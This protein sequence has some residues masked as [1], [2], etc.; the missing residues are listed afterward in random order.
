[1]AEAVAVGN[2]GVN[3]EWMIVITTDHGRKLPDS[4]GHGG[5]SDGERS[6]WVVTNHKNTNAYFHKLP[7]TVDIMPS[8]MHHLEIDIPQKIRTEI[9]GTSF[10]GDIAVSNLKAE[11]V[12]SK[13]NLSWKSYGN[14]EPAILSVATTN[15]FKSGGKDDY[16]KIKEIN[17][18]VESA[19]I[20]VSEMPSDFYKVLLTTSKN[21]LNY[22][23][24][25]NEKEA[26]DEEK[27]QL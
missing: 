6:V 12:D 17:S 22:W 19:T 14:K 26:V 27:S 3:E 1:M 8:I 7:G 23:I 18:T 24:V 20:D 5:Q 2:A 25:V 16:K 13:I 9:D 11:I 15:N 4:K 10:V 21:T